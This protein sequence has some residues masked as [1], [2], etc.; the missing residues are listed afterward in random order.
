[1]IF[2]EIVVTKF[3]PFPNSLSITTVAFAGGT[4]KD[5]FIMPAIHVIIFAIANHVLEVKIQ[6]LL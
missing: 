4:W 5:L 1:M 6:D 2:L 3:Y